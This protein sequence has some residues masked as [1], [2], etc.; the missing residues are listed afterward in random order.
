VLLR[1]LLCVAIATTLVLACN[2]EDP[3]G[4]DNS[5]TP[6]DLNSGESAQAQEAQQAAPRSSDLR[7]LQADAVQ[8]Q[9]TEQSHTESHQDSGEPA[10]SERAQPS[11]SEPLPPRPGGPPE[12]NFDIEVAVR[13][14]EH[15]AGEL[16]PRASG[17]EQE[18]AAAEYLSDTFTQ[19]GYETEIQ[20]FIIRSQANVGRIDLADGSSRLAFRFPGSRSDGVAGVLVE[21]P[22]VGEP[23]DFA[24]VDVDGKIA[25]V[26]RGVIEFRI[27]AANA[28]AAGAAALIIANVQVGESLSGSLRNDISNIPVLLVS[29]ELGDELRELI[30]AT[31]SISNAASSNG[32]SQNVIARTPNGACRVVVGGHYDTVPGVDGAN[33]NASGA[34]LTL[35]LA[36]IWSDHPSAADICFI[37]FGAE[38]I[39]LHGSEAY[40]RSL[41]ENG[42]LGNVTAMLNMDA[43]GDGEAPYQIVVSEPLKSMVEGM[44]G[45]LQIE[46]YAGNLPLQIGSDHMNFSNVGVPVVFVFPLGGIIH[47][48]LDNLENI[49]RDLYT[50]IATLNHAVLACLLERAGS[51]ITPTIPCAL[52]QP[53]ARSH[54]TLG[55]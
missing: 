6:A 16:G 53:G 40:V 23:E 4:P 47:S 10:A 20:Q 55:T 8:P 34:A 41:R 2:N 14:L 18:F 30:G 38:E 54:A 21:A 51:P 33:D 29:Q 31:I 9:P 13:Y 46:A 32:A 37:G 7:D 39:G 48:P 49:D 36:E 27:K 45:S 15:L 12:P 35:A 50:D 44:A 42:Q 28:E 22:G 17:T 5:A 26:E 11:Q 3:Q 19:L 24:S 43:I 1:P 52:E 25:F